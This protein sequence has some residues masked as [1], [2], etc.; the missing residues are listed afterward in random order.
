MNGY[1]INDFLIGFDSSTISINYV[2]DKK[3]RDDKENYTLNQSLMHYLKTI[4]LEIDNVNDKWDTYK[5]V[6][7]KYEYINTTVKVE[8]L[9]FNNTVCCYKPISRSYFKLIEILNFYDFN[10][11]DNM[12]SFHLAEG[13]GGFIEALT[14]HRNNPKDSYYGITLMEKHRD[15]PKWNKI[16]YFLSKHKNIH[17]V[18]GPQKDGNLYFKHNLNYFIENHYNKYDF[19]TGDGGFDYS[20]DFNKQEE[21]SINLIFC[22]VLYAIVMQ[23]VGGSF[24]L[25]VFDSFHRLT[26]EVIYLLCIFYSE[27]Y[28]F[29]PCTSREANSE[30]YLICRGFRDISNRKEILGLLMRNFDKMST[31]KLDSIFSLELNSFFMSKMQEI[32]AIFGQQQI[33]NILNTLNLIRDNVCQNKEKMMKMKQT[34]IK[35]CIQWCEQNQQTYYDQLQVLKV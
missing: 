4:K 20:T 9:N 17:I 2:D 10:F 23:K 1:L 19:V 27:V 25:K 29:K 5:R 34:N 15:V 18:Y 12:K 35:K 8:N 21:N 7:N 13:P 11:P 26:L 30:K 14:N 3:K 32:N 33:M 22:E 16:K 6:T 28:M 24:V 31:H